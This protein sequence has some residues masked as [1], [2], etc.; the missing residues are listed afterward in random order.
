MQMIYIW[1]FNVKSIFYK[2]ERAATHA[3]QLL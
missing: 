1:S 2:K 3:D